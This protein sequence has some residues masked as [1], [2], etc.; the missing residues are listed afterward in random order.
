MP[1]GRPALESPVARG[2]QPTA[3]DLPSTRQTVRCDQRLLTGASLPV[4][5]A[6]KCR[7]IGP[8]VRNVI[9]DMKIRS[10]TCILA[11]DTWNKDTK[12]K[13][14]SEGLENDII[15]KKVQKRGRC[16]YHWRCIKN[17]YD[18]SLFSC[19]ATRRI[20]HKTFYYI[21]LLFTS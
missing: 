4:F 7:S 18:N 14:Q 12:R 17:K 16:V 15:T 1:A 6:Q 9:K 21:C 5:S 2:I 3:R 20:S 8:K 11:S 13:Y 19:Q 10:T